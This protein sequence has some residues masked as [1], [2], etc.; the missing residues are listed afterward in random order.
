MVSHKDCQPLSV[1][2]DHGELG[3][4]SNELCPLLVEDKEKFVF[5]KQYLKNI[6]MTS[7]QTL[8]LFEDTKPQEDLA[9]CSLQGKMV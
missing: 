4:L 9:H 3:C 2:D 7:A 8:Q 6:L 1:Q 5:N